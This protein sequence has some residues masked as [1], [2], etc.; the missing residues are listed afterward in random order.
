MN[1]MITTL[2]KVF[3]DSDILN[4]FGCCKLIINDE[5]VWDDDVEWSEYIRFTDALERYMTTHSDWESYKVIDINIKIVHLHHSIISV[6]CESE[7]NY[8]SV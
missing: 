2:Q 8:E 1:E 5:V 3:F 6:S 7:I 4:E